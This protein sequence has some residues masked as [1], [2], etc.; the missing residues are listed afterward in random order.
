METFI[1]PTAVIY[2]NVKIGKGVYI[3]ALC[4]IGAPPESKTYFYSEDCPGVVIGDYAVITGNVTIDAGTVR[5]T[6]IGK[7]SFIM[8]GVHIGHDAVIGYACTLSPHVKIGGHV[9]VGAYTNIGMGA[10]VHQR[11]Y[12]PDRCMIGMNSTITKKTEMESNGVYVGSP[13]KFIRWNNRN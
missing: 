2:P 8:K 11:L 5:E 3:G 7:Y 12:V 6:T 4:I 13:A 10:A 1:H 9:E